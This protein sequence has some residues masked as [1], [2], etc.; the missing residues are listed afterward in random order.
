MKESLLDEYIIKL[1]H[2]KKECR[3]IG[4]DTCWLPN[5]N[6]RKEVEQY[7]IEAFERYPRMNL[8]EYCIIGNLVTIRESSDITYDINPKDENNVP[9]GEIDLLNEIKD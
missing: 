2:S 8:L 3:R 5:M 4:Y 1:K 9:I 7:I 6:N